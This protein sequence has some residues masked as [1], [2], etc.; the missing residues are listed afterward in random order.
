LKE[1]D[2]AELAAALVKLKRE[3]LPAPEEL[4]LSMELAKKPP[5]APS[6]PKTAFAKPQSADEDVEAP[7]HG[8]E[9]PGGVWFRINIGRARNADPRWLLPIICRKGGV[10]RRHVGRI[11]IMANETRFEVARAAATHFRKAAS[12]PDKKDPNLKITPMEATP[13]PAGQRDERS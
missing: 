2:A 6:P 1:R 13:K 7:S 4:P 9:K 12:K 8:R 5:R 10:D 11:E 3:A